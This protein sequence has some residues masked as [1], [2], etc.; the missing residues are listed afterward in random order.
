MEHRLR[1]QLCLIGFICSGVNGQSGTQP[2]ILIITVDDMSADSIGA[3]GCSLANTTPNID[4]LAKAK[5][6]TPKAN[7]K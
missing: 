5:R 3:F 6:Q 1:I 4:R 7:T 2:N